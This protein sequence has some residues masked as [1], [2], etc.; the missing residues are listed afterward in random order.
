MGPEV[1]LVLRSLPPPRPLRIWR[2]VKR[3]RASRVHPRP[4][5]C[6]Q[7]RHPICP[8]GAHIGCGA[9]RFGLGVIHHSH[10]DRLLRE[11][12][13]VFPSGG[14]ALAYTRFRSQSRRTIWGRFFPDFP[15]K[16]TRLF[17]RAKLQAWIENE[18]LPR[19]QSLPSPYHGRLVLHASILK[20][21]HPRYCV[22]SCGVLGRVTGV[23]TAAA[24]QVPRS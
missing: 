23:R 11:L 17:Q 19:V 18:P 13:K 15:E 14:V 24:R 16:E 20:A 7:T 4:A 9:G 3:T 21:E 12:A 10:R 5:A 8:A 2:R 1:S 22:L 6:R